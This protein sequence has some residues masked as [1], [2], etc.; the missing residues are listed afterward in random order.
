MKKL[1]YIHVLALIIFTFCQ[2]LFLPARA[3]LYMELTQGV[4]QAIPITIDNFHGPLT[5]ASGGQTLDNIIRNDLRDSG[6]FQLVTAAAADYT[7]QGSITDTAAGQYSVSIELKSA[8]NAPNGASQVLFNKVFQVKKSDLRQ[9]AHTI[10]D[11]VYEQ[12]T[13]VRGIFNTK[14]AYVLRQ[15]PRGADP[16]YALEVADADGYHPQTLL[17]SPSP[18][19]SPTWSPNGQDIA[20]VSFEQNR[21]S[22]YLQNLHSGQRRLITS[23]DGINGAPTFSPDGSQ[24]AVV[25][26]KTDNPKIYVVNLATLQLKQITDGYSI[27]TEPRWAADGRSL[28]FT[29]DRSGNPQI[30]R[31]EFN[32]GKITR[33]TYQGNY[34]ARPSLSA[35]GRTLVF[36][37]RETGVFGIAKEDLASGRLQILT[38]TGGEESPSLAPNGKMVLYATE[39]KGRGILGVVSIDGRVKLRLPSRAG[40]VQEPAWS[41]YL[42]TSS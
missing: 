33:L 8:F 23:F 31:Y 20:Y 32:S 35:D 38:S 18:I 36:M 39:Y 24:M 3:E 42:T 6:Q 29:S 28:I 14:M 5:L 21:A 12:L 34:N 13:G 22:I 10:S 4:N 1:K 26:T 2:F 17:V 40:T 37:H 7:L 16:I 9:L 25:L 41:P 27:D 11:I 30:Y 15:W 19:M